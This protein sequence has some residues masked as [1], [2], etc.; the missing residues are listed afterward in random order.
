MG[1][2]LVVQDLVVPT[3]AETKSNLMLFNC[4]PLARWR[5]IFYDGVFHNLS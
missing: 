1:A 4:S 3:Y 5:I 2:N